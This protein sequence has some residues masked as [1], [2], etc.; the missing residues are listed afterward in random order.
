MKDVS[1]LLNLLDL[2]Q[3]ELNLYR[4]QST[5][6]GS[7]SV[8]GGQV[9]AQ[10]VAAANRTVV[11]DRFLHSLHSYFILAGDFN[12]PIVYEVESVRDGGSFTTRRV[13]AIQKGRVIFF[14]ACSFQKRQEGFNH[15]IKM[16]NVPPPD[17]LLN[18]EELRKEISAQYPAAKRWSSF[19][20]PIEFRPIEQ[21]NP[22]NFEKQ[23]PFRHIWLRAKGTM[24]DD[25]KKHQE[26]LAYA[27]DY[28]LLWTAMLPHGE[29]A[30]LTNI[31][32]ASLDHSMWFHREFRADEWLLYALDSPSSSNSRGFC[33]GNIFTQD[34]KLVASVTQEGLMRERRK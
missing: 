29:Q 24:S 2:E 4:G 16:P 8:F 11:E 6:I 19:T 9:L 30:N 3:L 21:V 14:L 7:H 33:R 23:E 22:F 26:V 13:K 25:L 5:N 27:S 15:Q 18:Q 17:D 34:G 32:L 1:E 10:A 20:R 31:F 12:F 28:N